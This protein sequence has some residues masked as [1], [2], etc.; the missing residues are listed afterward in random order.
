MEIKVGNYNVLDNGSIVCMDNYP[1]TF[2]FGK[3]VYKIVIHKNEENH[4]SEDSIVFHRSC[5]NVYLGEIHMYLE[6]SSVLASDEPY[7]VGDYN[8]KSL[9]FAFYINN[10]LFMESGIPVVLNYMW[11][12]RDSAETLEQMEHDKENTE[13]R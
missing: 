13:K 2:T 1:A 9:Y 8:G 11:L 4:L 7:K 3:L 10:F 12:Q 6:P 5:E